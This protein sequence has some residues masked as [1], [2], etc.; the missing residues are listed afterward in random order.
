VKGR[1]PYNWDL[2][3]Y[4]GCG[5]GCQ[6]CFAKY[7]HNYLNSESFF[8]DIY[9][10]EN[11]VEV[12]ERELSSK[13]WKRELVNIGGVT[14]SYQPIEKEFKLMPEILKLFIKYRTPITISTKSDLILR[15]IDLISK[16][17]EITN[18][19]IAATI[20]TPD[21]RIREKTEPGA[22]KSLERF[23]MLKEIKKTKATTALHLMP[24]I[25]YLTDGQNDL[26]TLFKIASSCE[27]DYVI[28]GKLYLRGKTR[29][30]FLSFMRKEYEEE[31]LRLIKLY[32]KTDWD[33]PNDN[34]TKNYNHRLN[35]MLKH[36]KIKYHLTGTYKKQESNEN[37][38]LKLF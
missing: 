1:F 35:L 36:L 29:S 5:H 15:D 28:T 11:I 19:N 13:S 37:V 33:T 9:V 34:E 32:K 31:F 17:S 6:Y 23:R 21:E 12:L 27:V 26:E 10:K 14:D 8:S 18:V 22:V 16:L 24:I 38:Q 7:S 20:T 2:N 25:P 30:H 3:I 4:R